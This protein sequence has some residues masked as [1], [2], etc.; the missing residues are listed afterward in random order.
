MRNYSLP[1]R[2]IA[3]KRQMKDAVRILWRKLICTVQ[4]QIKNAVPWIFDGIGV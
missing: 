3:G 2:W 1:T 4:G